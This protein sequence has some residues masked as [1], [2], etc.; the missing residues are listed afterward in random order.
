MADTCEMFNN[1]TTMTEH[2]PDMFRQRRVVRTHVVPNVTASSDK[3]NT[4]KTM[5][6]DDHGRH[7][8]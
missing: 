2:N 8:R 6:S 3:E 5:H 4:N 7:M 1:N